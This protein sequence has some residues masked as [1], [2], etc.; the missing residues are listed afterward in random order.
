MDTSPK[1]VS[2]WPVAQEKMLNVISDQGNTTSNQMLY[3]HIPTRT[4]NGEDVKHQKSI[5]C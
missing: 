2:E 4:A 3:H 5:H 1:K